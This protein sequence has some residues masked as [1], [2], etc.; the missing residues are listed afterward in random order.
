MDLRQRHPPEDLGLGG[1]VDAAASIN[2]VGTA[3]MAE[4]RMTMAKPVWIQIRITISHMLLNG[5]SWKKID[6]LGVDLAVSVV[7]EPPMPG[8]RSR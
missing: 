8:T 4:D 5:R 3:L 1:A 6:R 2:S 7:A